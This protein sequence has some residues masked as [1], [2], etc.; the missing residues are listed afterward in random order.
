MSRSPRH[1][2]IEIRHARGCRV[3]EGGKCS[4]RPTYRGYVRQGDKKIRGPTFPSLGQARAWRDDARV[5]LRRGALHAPI[6]TTIEEAGEALLEGMKTGSILDRTGKPYKPST[7]RRYEAA[8]RRYVNPALGRARL[9]AVHRRDVQQL[10]DALRADGLR[11]S[12]VH[13]T[14]DPLRVIYRRAIRA[15]LLTVDP[16]KNL[17]LPAVRDGRDRIESPEAA[18]ELLDALP[19]RERAL[20]SLLLLAGVRRGEARA[21]R[22]S[23]F[24]LSARIVRI[25]RGWD[26]Y[27]GEIEVKSKAGRRTIPLAGRVRKEV[28]A[29]LLRTG[30]TGD[31][32][33]FGRTPSDPFVPSTL[34][35][36]AVRAWRGAGL[37]PMTP[38][39]ARHCAISY[40]IACGYDWKQVSVWAGHGDVRQTWNRYGKLMPDGERD[41]AAQLDAFLE[42]RAQS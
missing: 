32:L 39:E 30:R 9:S 41:A 40:F 29:H 8:L 22:C 28:A 15:D 34:R 33:I 11:P 14:L 23:D 26:D 20:W 31:D 7:T 10:V 36:T 17:E 21:L 4:C 12:T 1:A 13:K 42:R 27:E 19:E 6:P 25:E 2:G 38:H 5:E 37:K 35:R 16:T 18:F 3:G 24:D